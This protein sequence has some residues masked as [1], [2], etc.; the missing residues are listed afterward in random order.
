MASNQDVEINLG[1]GKL[2]G[3]FF[4]LCVLCAIFFALGYSLGKN[5][6]ATVASADQPPAAAPN[7]PAKPHG[8]EPAPAP[9]PSGSN[10]LTFFKSVQQSEPTPTLAPEAPAEPAPRKAAA[11]PPRTSSGYTVQIAAV[12]R[13]E[14]AQ[15]LMGALRK[16][17]YPVFIANNS[18]SDKLYHVQVGPFSQ[19]SDAEAMRSRLSNDGYNPILKK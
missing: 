17:N 12:T 4:G 3:L 6:S 16:K 2:L 8:K 5:S 13:Q 18:P 15:V 10:E 9:A 1:T 14:D 19:I 7:N 11:E